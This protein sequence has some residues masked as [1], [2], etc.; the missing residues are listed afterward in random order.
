MLVFPDMELINPAYCDNAIRPTF[1]N[2]GVSAQSM[3]L[4]YVISTHGEHLLRVK[5]V[6]DIAGTPGPA[7]IGVRHIFHEPAHLPAWPDND[8]RSRL[9]F[10]LRDLDPTAMLTSWREFGAAV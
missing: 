5:R 4:S 3:W 7:V 2:P 6:N 8:R 1:P 9:P 10:I